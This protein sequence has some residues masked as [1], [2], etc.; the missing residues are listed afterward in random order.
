MARIFNQGLPKIPAAMAS[1]K[2]MRAHPSVVGERI[3]VIYGFMT[4][5]HDCLAIC[6]S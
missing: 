6:C 2:L 3:K 4:Q 1:V 5:G